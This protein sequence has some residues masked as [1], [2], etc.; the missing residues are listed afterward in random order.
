MAKTPLRITRMNRDA[1]TGK[2]SLDRDCSYQLIINPA[3]ITHGSSIEYDKPEAMEKTTKD[4]RFHAYGPETIEFTVVFDGTGAVPDEQDPGKLD[5]MGQIK[6]LL[7]VI[8]DF[9]GTKHEPNIVQIT[10]GAL[11][12]IARLDSITRQYTLFRPSGT[13][14][15][16]KVNLRFS[17]YS[18]RQE[19]ALAAGRN[20]PDLS[21][22][23]EVRAGDTLPLLCQ[24][25][26]G[27]SRYYM[28]VARFNKL[29]Q[30]RCLTPGQKL[31]FPP[32]D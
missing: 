4:V 15:R 28:H 31:H 1:K 32:L 7:K 6:F 11:F 12:W 17:G 21:H 9:N 3:E 18:S 24:S 10:W 26:Y 13:P 29:S 5:V 19:A 22:I 8:Y 20:S 14:L 25:I 2:L 30:F 27:D 16:A 23:V